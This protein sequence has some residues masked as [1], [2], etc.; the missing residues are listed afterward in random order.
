MAPDGSDVRLYG[1]QHG[2]V[3]DSVSRAL[4]TPY[5]DAMVVVQQGPGGDLDI[6][7]LD[8]DGRTTSIVSAPGAQDVDPD[9]L[10]PQPRGAR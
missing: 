6:V 2:C 5:D 9:L 8:A 7:R 10:T 1:S 3:V 4:W